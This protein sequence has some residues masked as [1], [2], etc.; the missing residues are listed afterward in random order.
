[1]ILRDGETKLEIRIA[2]YQFPELE[3]EPWDSDWLVVHLRLDTPLGHWERLNPCLTTFEVISLI[4][5]LGE[6][7]QHFEVFESWRSINLVTR[8]L[9]TEP[10]LSFQVFSQSPRRNR[11]KSVVFRVYLEAEFLPPYK[12]QLI[13]YFDSDGDGEVYFDFRVNKDALLDI[14]SSF[15]SQLEHFPERVG[16]PR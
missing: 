13:R 10:N 15:A 8:E 4:D 14:I 12:D 16:L 1:M 2:G 9:F 7:V 11:E 6:V 5:W 3:N